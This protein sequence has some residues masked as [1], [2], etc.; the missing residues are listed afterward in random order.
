L[1]DWDNPF[2]PVRQ[3]IAI[4]IPGS[5]TYKSKRFTETRIRADRTFTLEV[6]AGGGTIY[7]YYGCNT[8]ISWKPESNQDY[9]AEFHYG[10]QACL[11]SVSKVTQGADGTVVK[12]PVQPLRLSPCT[13]E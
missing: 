12:T 9:E 4:G 8:T 13:D 1:L 11:V 2:Y 5:D 10:V 7:S 6:G 3:G